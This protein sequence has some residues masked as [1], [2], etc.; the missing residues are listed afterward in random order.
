MGTAEDYFDLGVKLSEDSRCAEVVY[1]F[2]GAVKLK[3]DYA[4]AC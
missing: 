1:V 2:K 3:S 4:V